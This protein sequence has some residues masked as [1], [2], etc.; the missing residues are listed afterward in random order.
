MILTASCGELNPERLKMKKTNT[1]ISGF[2]A[3]R[4]PGWN[5]SELP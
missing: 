1:R 2:L 3:L 5:Y 4:I